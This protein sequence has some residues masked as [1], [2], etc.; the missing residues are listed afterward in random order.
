MDAM[1]GL[2]AISP[3]STLTFSMGLVPG[4]VQAP[5]RL[6]RHKEILD[7]VRRMSEKGKLVAA[8]RHGAWVPIST[9]ITGEN[10]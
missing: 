8:I 6:R 2:I 3:Q 4:G 1:A 9:G 10:V 5:D 7:F